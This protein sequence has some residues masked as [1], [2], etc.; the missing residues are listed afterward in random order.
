MSAIR[1]TVWE[2]AVIQDTKYFIV[3]SYRAGVRLY[4]WPDASTAET[5]SGSRCSMVTA[6]ANP[7]SAAVG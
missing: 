2:S 1:I 5:R 4:T 3:R 6:R 7:C